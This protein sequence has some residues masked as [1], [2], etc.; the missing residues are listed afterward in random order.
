MTSVMSYECHLGEHE[1][2]KRSIQDLD[3]E[4]VAGD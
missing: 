2:E 1:G 4:E 3:P